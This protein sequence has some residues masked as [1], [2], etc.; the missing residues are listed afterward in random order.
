MSPR[1]FIIATIALSSVSHA[2]DDTAF[3]ENRVR[4]LLIERCF[5]CH[6]QEKKIKGGLALDSRPG[7]Q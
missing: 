3:F 2:A 4:P 1:I 5:E 6:S 7:W